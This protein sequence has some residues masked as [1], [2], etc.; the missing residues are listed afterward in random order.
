MI[1]GLSDTQVV[2]HYIVPI[3]NDYHRSSDK[4][5]A[6]HFMV[7]ISSKGAS[8]APTVLIRKTSHMD[9]VIYLGGWSLFTL[10]L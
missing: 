7:K 8:E 1:R 4:I 9:A 10:C 5:I 6:R 2:I 3:C